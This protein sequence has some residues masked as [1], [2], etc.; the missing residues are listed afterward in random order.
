[1]AAQIAVLFAERSRVF[2]I[3][4]LVRVAVAR[5]CE[6]LVVADSADCV[7]LESSALTE[8]VFG[9][10]FGFRSLLVAMRN[11]VDL[12]AVQIHQT[13]SLGRIADGVVGHRGFNLTGVRILR[14]LDL[15]AICGL[16]LKGPLYLL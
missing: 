15:V 9:V 12:L 6:T 8:S 16:W 14:S 3:R 4:S 2:L 7:L 10:D 1:M 13:G 11:Q 5:I